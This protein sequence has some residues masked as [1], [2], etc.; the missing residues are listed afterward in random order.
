M[1]ASRPTIP[2][3]EFTDDGCEILR[4]IK[5]LNVTEQREF[6]EDLVEAQIVVQGR[7]V[8]IDITE[9]RFGNLDILP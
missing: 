5:V 9:V 4:S 6:L 1:R 8:G 3:G 7:K 2:T